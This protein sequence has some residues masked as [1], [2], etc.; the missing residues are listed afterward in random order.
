M[1]LDH[2]GPR[3]IVPADKAYNADFIRE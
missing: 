1:L 3:T 2:L